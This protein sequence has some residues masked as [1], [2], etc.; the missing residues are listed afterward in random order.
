MTK[1]R[2]EIAKS[3]D[4]WECGWE[5]NRRFQLRYFRALS[6]TDKLR[7]VEEMAEIVEFFSQRARERREQAST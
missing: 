7:A 2:W 6:I 1:S 5:E 4:N 3:A